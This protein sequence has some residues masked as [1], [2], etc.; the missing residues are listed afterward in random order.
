MTE[1]PRKTRFLS[2]NTK[3]CKGDIK[4][5]GCM[6]DN[7][8]EG[9]YFFHVHCEWKGKLHNIGTKIYVI[10]KKKSI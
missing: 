9:I 5:S 3:T 10:W 7:T 4:N 1:S 8:N 2:L 6:T